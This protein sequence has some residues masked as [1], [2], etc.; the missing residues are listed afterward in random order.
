MK[1]SEFVNK[2]KQWGSCSKK[3]KCLQKDIEM[4]ADEG[5]HIFRALKSKCHVISE[6]LSTKSDLH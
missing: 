1:G 2:S 4:R 5:F 3:A 6:K